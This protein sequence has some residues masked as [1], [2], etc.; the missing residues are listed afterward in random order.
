M[1]VSMS[2]GVSLGNLVSAVTDPVTGGVANL[3]A[4]G[5]VVNLSDFPLSQR[6][7]KKWFGSTVSSSTYN[8][9]SGLSA[10]KACYAVKLDA[11]ADFDAVRLV[12]V[13]RAANAIN[14]CTAIVGIT[15]TA[16][17]DTANHLSQVV[18]GGTAYNNAAAGTSIN[19]WYPVTWSSGSASVNIGAATTAAQY[20]LSDWIPVSSIARA[21]GGS[22]PLLIYACQHDGT[23]ENFAF[24]PGQ[25]C[26]GNRIATSANR[27]RIVQL[28]KPTAGA[29]A[30]DPA[31][32]QSVFT[33]AAFEVFPIFRYR[34]PS[35]TVLIAGDSTEQN[36]AL[37]KD[38]LS[39]WGWRGCA[40][41]SSTNRPVNCINVG[42]S[43][44][45]ASEYWSRTQE[46]I[47][48]GVVPDVLV[49]G[50]M[51]VND[52]YQ[53]NP[54]RSFQTGRARALEI[55]DYARSSGIRYVLFIPLLPYNTLN[56]L[57]DNYRK[58]FNSWLGT[59]GSG[60]V[61]VLSFSSLGDGATP[62]K[63][64]TGYNVS[65]G[66]QIVSFD[67]PKSSASTTSYVAGTTYVA[68]VTIDS[69]GC[70]VSFLGSA[71][72][73]VGDL[74]SV[75]NTQINTG[76]STVGVTYASMYAGNILVQSATTGA[77]ST[78]AITNPGGNYAFASPL[79]NF[80]AVNSAVAGLA[81]GIHPNENAIDVVMAPALTIYIN[82]I[83]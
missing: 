31:Q 65:S 2:N 38:G 30:P 74:V 26:I 59:I 41:A 69:T 47:A 55:L 67:L 33:N 35:L 52:T 70:A 49:I 81:D 82:S 78:V 24:L 76:M 1:T 19:G 8:Q 53:T 63:W 37:V 14:S 17:Y 58:A 18:I 54:D 57:Q 29:S 7:A 20:A 71:A 79:A 16:E 42:C 48:A 3:S 39:S 72:S 64:V 46:I 32:T 40:D 21:D 73:T 10:S 44:K 27:G 45:T 6:G 15:E 60:V 23:A 12:W 62:E 36:D 75:L 43:S 80:A 83:V 77:S 66:R 13:N 68:T 4:A 28:F 9:S 34:V 61:D 25:M 5:K 56:S 11:E 51:S 22:R 50:P